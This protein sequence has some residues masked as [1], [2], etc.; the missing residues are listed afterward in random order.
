MEK[1]KNTASTCKKQLKD[2]RKSALLTVYEPGEACRRWWGPWFSSRSLAP[3]RCVSGSPGQQQAAHM[4]VTTSSKGT[5]YMAKFPSH[6]PVLWRC[7]DMWK[8][9]FLIKGHSM[10]V[11]FKLS[12]T[13][14][15]A[16]HMKVT[17]LVKGTQPWC[18][19]LWLTGL[20]A[21]TN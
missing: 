2:K 3:W 11:F 6:S 12:G 9:S 13:G 7:D 5:L 18:N 15:V 20:K 16:C 21:P 8:S 17:V 1:K 19:P 10:A 14:K 4:K